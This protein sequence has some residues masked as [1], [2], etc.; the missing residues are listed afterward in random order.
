K[1]NK[2]EELAK[3]V[4][5]FQLFHYADSLDIILMII[6]LV[7]SAAHGVALPLMIIVFGQ[8]TD[9]FVSSG[10]QVNITV[11]ST[12]NAS[13]SDCPQVTGVDI[14]AA[15]TRFAYYF[16]AIG[17]SVLVLA[18]IQVATF[19]LSSSRQTQRIRE[20]FFYAVL[21]QHMGWFD[22]HELGTLNTRLTE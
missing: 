7:C 21:H 20:K 14:Q 10:I 3:S 13:S 11:N 5:I 17:F 22:A 8:M 1:K 16:I 18:T 15:M 6:G 12:L 2:K 4:G 19:L 9:S